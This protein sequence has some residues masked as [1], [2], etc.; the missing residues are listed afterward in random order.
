MALD[1]QL[2]LS[3]TQCVRLA[4]VRTSPAKFARALEAAKIDPGYVRCLCTAARSRLVIRRKANAGTAAVFFVAGWPGAGREHDMECP[5]YKEAEGEST[6]ASLTA[7]GLHE[8]DDGSFKITPAFSLSIRIDARQKSDPRGS[9]AKTGSG[10]RG[11]SLLA[12]LQDMWEKRGLHRWR[13]GWSR[14]WSRIRIEAL[15]HAERGC[16]GRVSMAELLYVPPRFDSANAESIRNEFAERFAPLYSSAQAFVAAE[17]ALAAGRPALAERKTALILATLRTVSA[18]QFGFDVRLGQ[19][20]RPIYCKNILKDSLERRF[21]RIDDPDRPLVGLFH[22][23]GT[24][25]GHLSLLNAGLMQV[26]ARFIPVES[27]YEKEVADALIAADRSFEKPM[28]YETGEGVLPDFILLDTGGRPCYMEI[29]GVTGRE[30]YDERKAQKRALY[31]EKGLIVWEWD[32]TRS[33]EMPALPQK[34]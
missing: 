24:P 21:G 6:R 33:R 8:N 28:R 2:Q 17:K 29:Y 20:S 23:E 5:F 32:V 30:K 12:V 3:E 14:D 31:R 7:S 10:T 13:A 25:R 15:R 26:A 9:R 1:P 4:D 34:R 11:L 22:V 16:L 18:T 27:S 19:V